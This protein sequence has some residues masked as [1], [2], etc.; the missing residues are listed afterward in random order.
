MLLY[1]FTAEEYLD[2][3]LAHGLDCG[4]LP[5]S[6]TEV[7]SAVNLTSD[8]NPGG[9]GLSDGRPL[10]DDEIAFFRRT[11]TPVADGARIPNKR[12]I[13]ITV[14]V[15]R[16]TVKRWLPW[17]RKK[18]DALFLKG[19]IDS[20]GGARKA[21]SWWFSHKPIPRECFV[22]VERSDGKGGWT[23]VA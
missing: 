22:A 13:R 10:N 20:G 9:H 11:G 1:H 6:A 4:E 17:A 23:R 8:P 7:E 18:L 15:P 16:S 5:L 12:A 14:K 2:S 3:I 19:M 21:K